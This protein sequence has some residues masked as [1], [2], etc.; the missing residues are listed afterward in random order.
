M[1][2]GHCS[3][4]D[5][6]WHLHYTSFQ[7]KNCHIWLKFTMKFTLNLLRFGS[8][9][10]GLNQVQA[11]CYLNLELDLR[12]GSGWKLNLELN[13]GLV[14]IGSGLNLGS[15]PNLAI[16]TTDNDSQ[17]ADI[18]SS[19]PSLLISP[20]DVT[21]TGVVSVHQSDNCCTKGALQCHW[22]VTVWCLALFLTNM[23]KRLTDSQVWMTVTVFSLWCAYRRW[24]KLSPIA[25]LADTGWVLSCYCWPGKIVDLTSPPVPY[26]LLP[27]HLSDDEWYKTCQSSD[28][29]QTQ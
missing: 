7:L 15:E 18:F 14:R 1:C 4:I 12:F 25:V 28:S 26:L 2:W 11:N 23:P 20:T 5:I 9:W 6:P 21:Q 3:I 19:L 13:L 24:P 22:S 29:S 27:D 10:T 8:V 17:T 16:T